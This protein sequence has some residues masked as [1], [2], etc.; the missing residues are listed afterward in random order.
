MS[1]WYEQKHVPR[2]TIAVWRR[3]RKLE[4]VVDAPGEL[5]HSEQ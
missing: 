1:R 5:V 3:L 2:R 4:R